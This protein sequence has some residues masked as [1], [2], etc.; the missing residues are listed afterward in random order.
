MP[1]VIGGTLDYGTFDGLAMTYEGQIIT[2]G[3]YY[4]DYDWNSTYFYES[5]WRVDFYNGTIITCEPRTLFEVYLV[6]AN[7]T[8]VYTY[9]TYPYEEWISR[10]P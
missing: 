10:R 3:D 8:L 6:D 7:G 4:I 2:P 1:D 5:N 9:N